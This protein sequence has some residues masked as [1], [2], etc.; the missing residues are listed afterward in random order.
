M[1]G[2]TEMEKQGVTGEPGNGNR[3]F[4][5]E[6]VSTPEKQRNFFKVWSTVTEACG[7][8]TDDAPF[9]QVCDEIFKNEWPAGR[10]A[11]TW[12]FEELEKIPDQK[13]REKVMD[14]AQNLAEQ[15]RN[16]YLAVGFALSMDYEITRPDAREAIDYL[17]KKIRESGI[18]PLIASR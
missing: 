13:L 11:T 8:G 14:S 17:R 6:H 1:K 3:F 7:E 5:E 4:A 10:E 2:E 12:L 15:S 16:F 9:D 18:F